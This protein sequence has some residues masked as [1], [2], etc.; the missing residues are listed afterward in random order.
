MAVFSL[1]LSGGTTNQDPALSLGGPPSGYPV[2]QG[3]LNNLFPDFTGRDVETSVTDHRCVYAFND[4]DD[5]LLGVSVWIADQSQDGAEVFLGFT[6][7][8]EVQQLSIQGDIEGGTLSLTVE[9]NPLEDIEWGETPEE[10]ASNIQDAIN[11]VAGFEDVTVEATAVNVFRVTFAGN[12][13]SRV[14]QAI[15]M[16]IS[17]LEYPETDDPPV[18]AVIVVTQGGPINSVAPL[19]D[20]ATSTPPNVSFSLPTESTPKVFGDLAPGE[21]FPFWIRR[22]VTPDSEPVASDGV[23]IRVSGDLLLS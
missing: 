2:E 9:S 12:T 20:S 16:D 21:G 17:G 22:Q 23:T 15:T 14:R 6:E 8:D 18:G 11:A 5:T 1:V 10:T 19:S 7:N 4:S 3:V 13:G